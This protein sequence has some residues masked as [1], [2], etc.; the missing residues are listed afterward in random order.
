MMIPGNCILI[1]TSKFPV[2]EGE[3]EKLVNEGMYGKALCL[4]LEKELPKL[5]INVSSFCC[6]DW[7]WWVAVNSDE[8][9]M[10]LCI[11]SDQEVGDNP[12]RYAIMSSLTEGKKW[13]WSKF[14]KIDV[15]KDVTRIMDMTEKLFKDDSEITQVSRHD[16]YPL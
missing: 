3:E 12:T 7:G 11:Y 15:S 13:M 2:L 10:G 1:E 16:D 9:E 4:Y 5:D 8:F 14:R 6:E